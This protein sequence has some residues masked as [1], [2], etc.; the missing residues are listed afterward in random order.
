M[1]GKVNKYES[2]INVVNR[3]QAKDAD[4]LEPKGTWS[5]TDVFCSSVTVAEPSADRRDLTHAGTQAERGK[6]VV[7]PS[8]K[9]TAKRVD[10]TAGKGRWKKRRPFCNGMDRDGASGTIIPHESGQTSIRSFI[11]REFG[12]S[13][14]RKS[15][16]QA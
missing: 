6:P 16:W 9:Q 3:Q 2:L 12:K 7:L 8:G 11:T 4:R 13:S 14:P 15:R 5:G 1:H 10:R